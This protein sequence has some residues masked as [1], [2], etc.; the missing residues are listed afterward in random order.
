[1]SKKTKIIIAV[2]SIIVLIA[3]IVVVSFIVSRNNK[4][5][6]TVGTTWGDTYYAYLKEIKTADDKSE[7]GLEDTNN[8]SMGFV[9]SSENKNPVM[10]LTYQ[11]DNAEYSNLYYAETDGG[12]SF[13]QYSE[14]SS[15][16][17]L[18]NIEKSEYSWYLHQKGEIQI[19]QSIDSITTDFEDNNMDSDVISFSQNSFV[20]NEQNMNVSYFDTIFVETGISNNTIS[21]DFSAGDEDFRNSIENAVNGY[22][23][24]EQLSTDEVKQAVTSKVDEINSVLNQQKAQQE[25]EEAKLTTDNVSSRIGE[26]LKWFTS[27]YLGTTYG[28]RDV[29]EYKDVTGKVTVPGEGQYMMTYELVGLKSIND[30]KTSLEPYMDSN[31]I[32]KLSASPV[33]SQYLEEYNGKVYWLSGGVGDGPEIDYDR[34]KVISSDGT[35]S[36]VLLENYDVISNTKTEE[37]TL[38]VNFQD[39]KYIITDYEVNSLL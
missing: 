8:V 38:T 31:V 19:Y 25:I 28:W 12:I 24:D 39:G 7:Y 23:T 35:T 10:V 21:V 27:A 2:V 18:Y 29:F 22:K 15:V 33:F 13:M 37:I 30:L 32:S 14:P 11:K 34:A 26:N 6:K 16:E 1:M 5:N 17:Y 4:I 9:E 3:I 20:R 36:K